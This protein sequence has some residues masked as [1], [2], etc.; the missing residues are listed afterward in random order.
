MSYRRIWTFLLALGLLLS[1]AGQAMAAGDID[2][3]KAVTLT[4]SYQ[5][6]YLPISGARFSLYQVARAKKTGELTICEDFAPYEE[7]IDI[8]GRTDETDAA[9]RALA[10]TLEGFVLRDKISPIDEGKTDEDGL[11]S[12]PTS[13]DVTLL[14]GLYLVVG[15]RHL[16]GEYYYDPQAFLIMLPTIDTEENVWQ[17]HMAVLVKYDRR[18][19]RGDTP[20][21]DQSVVKIWED[22][23]AST[24]RPG[25]ITIDLLQDGELYD[26]VALTKE[27]NWRYTWKGLD[28]R[29]RYLAVERVP[30]G[31]AARTEREGNTIVLTNYAE[32]SQSTTE[33]AGKLPQTGALWW[34]VGVLG[35]CGAGCLLLSGIIKKR[36]QD[37]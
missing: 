7:S 4:L 24:S 14:P 22:G 29:H 37:G 2:T 18:P 8:R 13:E 12:F 23:G 5:D 20:G 10:L 27:N 34:P 19:A 16:Q 30:A 6:E 32:F 21:E 3:E 28:S 33:H 11:L 15:R 31:Y 36:E 26:T 25:S 9:W 35:V 1:L 17:Y